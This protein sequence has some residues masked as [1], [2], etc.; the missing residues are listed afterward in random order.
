MY[1]LFSPCISSSGTFPNVGK[2]ITISPAPT[3]SSSLGHRR[4][5]QLWWKQ[6]HWLH[7][8]NTISCAPFSYSSTSRSI[9]TGKSAP[10]S[11]VLNLSNSPFQVTASLLSAPPPSSSCRGPGVPAG[12]QA[13]AL[14]G[15]E[16][17]AAQR[18]ETSRARKGIWGRSEG[19][20]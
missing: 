14:W 15:Q 16:G 6:G 10:L 2:T 7:S 5:G 17:T 19:C 12:P 18:S 11:D 20:A 4:L 3:G 1:L 13:S 8:L 9:G